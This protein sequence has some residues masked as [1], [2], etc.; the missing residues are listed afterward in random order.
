MLEEQQSHTFGIFFAQQAAVQAVNRLNNSG[1]LMEQVSVVIKQVDNNE[2]LD[3][4]EQFFWYSNQTG[5]AISIVGSLLGGICGCLVGIGVLAVPGV[6]PLI[7]VGT[8]GTALVAT[9]A[10]AGIGVVSGGLISV[11]D[12]TEISL[13]KDDCEHHF[14]AEYLVIVRGTD[15]E[16]SRAKSILGMS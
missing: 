6:G 11:L 4:A 12:S 1:F 9:L 10:G 3:G 14:Q 8:S 16:V 15:D 5:S 2:Q 7:A 13:D